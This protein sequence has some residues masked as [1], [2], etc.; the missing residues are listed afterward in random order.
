MPHSA[1]QFQAL[2]RSPM[3]C[4]RD[5]VLPIEW[6]RQYAEALMALVNFEQF[7]NNQSTGRA[8]PR[9]NAYVTALGVDNIANPRARLAGR[10]LPSL[11]LRS[12]GGVGITKTVLAPG[13]YAVAPE[14]NSPMVTEALPN[15]GRVV[16]TS[17]SHQTTFDLLQALA[18]QQPDIAN[19]LAVL[20]FDMH[21]DIVAHVTTK[22]PTK[23]RVMSEIFGQG[24]SERVGVAGICHVPAGSDHNYSFVRESDYL[25]VNLD[26]LQVSIS[27][28]LFLQAID[29]MFRDWQQQGIRIIFPSIDLDCLRLAEQVYTATDYNV[30]D[31]LRNAIFSSARLADRHCL[32]EWTKRFCQLEKTPKDIACANRAALFFL[33]DATLKSVARETGGIPAEWIVAAIQHAKMEFGF[34]IGVHVGNVHVIGDV[35]EYLPFDFEGRTAA[36]TTELLKALVAL[37]A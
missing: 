18:I 23:V 9:L 3:A 20:S 22:L 7:V 30:L 26:S 34:Q 19:R 10:D 13:G 32:V 25:N 16:C 4:C 31:G 28:P 17:N 2:V 33:S 14:L 29:Q 36:V 5:D 6:V 24:L 15:S 8:L 12:L 27:R 21:S 1:R 11:M 35:T 37:A